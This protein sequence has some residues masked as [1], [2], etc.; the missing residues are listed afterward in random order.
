MS[1]NTVYL[2]KGICFMEYIESNKVELKEMMT[3]EIKKEILAFL[4]TEGGTIYVGVKNDGMVVPYKDSKERD[5]MDIRISNWIRDVFYPNVSS[6]LRYHFNED[7]VFIIEIN[8]GIEKPYYL[9]EKGSK[10]SGVYVRIGRTSRMATESEIL[11][12]LLDSK[13]YSY[14]DDVSDEQ[15]LTFRFFN[16][17]CDE[18]NI[19]HEE[20]NLRSLRMINKDGKYTNL[21]F[22][23]SDQSDIVVKF[24]KYD[25][26]LDFMKK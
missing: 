1:T 15:D 23:M 20:R 26:N 12:M 5:E 4:N 18:N 19:P 11:L 21:G 8:Q 2:M 24:A 16:D 7:G 22:I 9:K 14:E 17:I 10:P 25:K 13:K 3:D 6:L